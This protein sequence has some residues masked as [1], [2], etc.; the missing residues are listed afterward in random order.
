MIS[1][2]TPDKQ[3][4]FGRINARGC[5]RYTRLCWQ[6]YVQPIRGIIFCSK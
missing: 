4:P 6:A 1:L 2:F 3:L 5:S